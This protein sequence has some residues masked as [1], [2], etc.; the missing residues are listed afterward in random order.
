[1]LTL[2]RRVKC[3][4]HPILARSGQP[5]PRRRVAPFER[6][7]SRLLVSEQEPEIECYSFYMLWS[8]AAQL[9]VRPLP[10]LCIGERQDNDACRFASSV[11]PELDLGT[12]TV[13]RRRPTF[14][15][16]PRP[17]VREP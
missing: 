4:H 13:E 15:D 14:D 11:G 3:L 16:A 17:H 10:F 5:L 12:R 1:M 2:Q 6:I 8:W 7:S 9:P